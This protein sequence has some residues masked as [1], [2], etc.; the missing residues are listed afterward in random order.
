M[1]LITRRFAELELYIL[2]IKI[3]QRFK[4][5]YHGTEVGMTTAFV[6]KPN[7]KIRLRLVK[8]TWIET[9][10]IRFFL[11]EISFAFLLQLSKRLLQKLHKLMDWEHIQWTLASWIYKLS[12][13]FLFWFCLPWILYIHC[14]NHISKK[15]VSQ[16]CILQM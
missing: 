15:I 7:K 2:M 16:Y 1:N 9:C 14:L 6:N 12:D 5:E 13:F 4:L 11:S 3:L 10:F 8:R